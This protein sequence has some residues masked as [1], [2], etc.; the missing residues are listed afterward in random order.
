MSE[1]NYQPPKVWVWNQ[2]DGGNW[3]E[4]KPSNCRANA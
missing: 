2:Q 3:S 1:N 4:D